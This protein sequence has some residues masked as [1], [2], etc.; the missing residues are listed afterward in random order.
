MAQSLLLSAALEH[1]HALLV[2]SQKALNTYKKLGYFH[3]FYCLQLHVYATSNQISR[4]SRSDVA[5]VRL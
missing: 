2:L 4:L 1:S 5:E 3:D